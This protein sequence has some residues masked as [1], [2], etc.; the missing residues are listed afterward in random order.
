MVVAVL[1]TQAAR[2]SVTQL[3]N[4]WTQGDIAAA[5]KAAAPGDTIRIPAGTAVVDTTIVID[6]PLTLIG[7]GIDQ[8]VLIDEVPRT[9]DHKQI[10]EVS[11]DGWRL[12][13]MTFRVGTVNTSMNWDGT[14]LLSGADFRLDHV[15]FDRLQAIG[16]MVYG[17]KALIDHSVFDQ[18]ELESFQTFDSAWGDDS[19]ATDLEWGSENLIYFED[20]TFLNHADVPGIDAY[21][22][23]RIVV[24]YNH[25]TYSWLGNHGTDTSQ[26]QRGARVMEV[27]ENWFEFPFHTEWTP[28]PWAIYMRSG[29][30]VIFNNHFRD[31][32]SACVA[33]AN[34]RSILDPKLEDGAPNWKP[35]GGA[36]GTMTP[37]L[38]PNATT[39]YMAPN[40]W[41][42]NV[43]ADGYPA[44]DQVGR[45]TS[46][47]LKDDPPIN[48]KTG[49]SSWPH[50]M[51]DPVYFWNNDQAIRTT[52]D[53]SSQHSVIQRDRDYI[54]GVPRPS[55][56]PFSYPHP[57]IALDDPPPDGGA[58][59]SGTTDS[60]TPAVGSAANAPDGGAPA[61]VGPPLYRPIGSGAGAS[62]KG[63]CSMAPGSA[64]G[65]LALL[66]ASGLYLV[67]RRRRP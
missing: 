41:D 1:S 10:F 47:R 44:L 31:D 63:G 7:A 62:V 9:G 24:R 15:K 21:G 30:A 33:L 50:N 14:L 46:D 52:S 12:S 34:Y 35:W 20:N 45:G 67:P 6:K 29:T 26:R 39:P 2:A 13:G 42:G 22:G 55:Y 56:V 18:P 53:I 4:G 38:D 48:A 49:T 8:T 65:P 57:R 61:S 5:V 17:R 36:Y 40:P 11:G 3:A 16:A 37:N 59:D 54:V 27:Y 51:K 19:W 64:L 43:E 58:T 25:F 23:S 28:W 60:G 32:Y 66:L